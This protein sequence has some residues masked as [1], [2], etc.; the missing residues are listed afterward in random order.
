MRIKYTRPAQGGFAGSASGTESLVEDIPDTDPTTQQPA[1]VPEG[2]V[3]VASS[4]PIHGWQR[5][6]AGGGFPTQVAAGGN[7]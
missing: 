6:S 1:T 7:N 4:T 5:D 2:A 3:E